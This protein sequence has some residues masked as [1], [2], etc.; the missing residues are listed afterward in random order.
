MH[1]FENRLSTTILLVGSIFL[2][3]GCGSPLHRAAQEGNLA[4][5][6]AFVAQGN[7]INEWNI[8]RSTP[9]HVA[10]ENGHVKIVAFLLS[11]GAEINAKNSYFETPLHKAATK[12]HLAVVAYLVS[13]GA[14]IHLRDNYGNPPLSVAAKNG[15]AEVVKYLISVGARVHVVNNYKET[16]RFL[17]AKGGYID[18]VRILDNAFSIPQEKPTV[19]QPVYTRDQT[20]PVIRIFSPQVTR[21]IVLSHKGRRLSIVGRAIDESGLSQVKINGQV[22]K[23][24]E[25]GNFQQEITLISGDNEI[26]IVAM[27]IHGN[28][29]IQRFSI[30]H[31]SKT[32]ATKQSVVTG[33]YHALVIGN[34]QYWH[35][36]KL[37]T[38]K[39]DALAVSN[40]LRQQFGFETTL[41]LDAKKTEISRAFNRL[42]KKLGPQDNFLVY[43]AGHGYFDN[44]V[45]K[46]YWLPVDADKDDD[47]NWIIADTITANIQ[48]FSSNHVLVIADSCY[49]GTLTRSSRMDMSARGD[50]THFIRQM[51]TRRSR[52]LMASGGNEPVSDSGGGRHSVF[53]AAL[54]QGLQKEE[55]LTFT[56]E[57]LFYRFIKEN[58][59]G[60]SAQVPAYHIIRNSGHDGGDFVFRRS[61]K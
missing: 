42:R 28:Q 57:E 13:R 58:V 20:P 43:Y 25:F 50:R 5:V 44:T 32:L 61:T 16:A 9:L 33:R 55:K 21:G 11:Q 53:A 47:T 59:A 29:T 38:A 8:S 39:T 26:A 49:S 52:T 19:T 51:T 23:W 45:N 56:A 2:L 7:D 18:V 36:P 10:A 12:G 15:H 24:D 31:S 41:L 40:Q 27:D 6:Q 14:N 1:L 60:K 34:N 48:R 17:A 22:V 37:K 3:A 30:P 54:L 4:K 46:A 35:L